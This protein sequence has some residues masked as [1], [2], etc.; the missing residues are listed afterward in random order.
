M[1]PVVLKDF[2]ISIERKE[3]IRLLG[4]RGGESS[5]PEGR[6]DAA[7]DEALEAA[8]PLIS[9]AGVYKIVKGSDLASGIFASL[10]RIALCVCTIGPSLEEEVARLSAEGNLLR[11]VCLDAAGSAAAE[12]VACYFDDRI[13][14]RAAE[15]G[16]KTSCRAS[17]GYGDWDVRGQKDLFELVDGSL[18]GVT[19]SE[20]CMM[21]PRKSVSFALH[22]DEK[23]VR[24]RSENSCENCDME[25]CPYK[26]K[27][28]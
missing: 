14:E 9:P 10:E 26:R 23:P 6:A 19:L 17:P 12:T 28:E 25:I 15:T 22:I 4:S 18:A 7:V 24:L 16:L 20:T 5:P 13:K 8:G 1:D 27:T 21:T 3:V 11:A 2:E